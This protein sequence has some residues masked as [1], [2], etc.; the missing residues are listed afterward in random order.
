MNNY[1]LFNMLMIS[2]LWITMLV[3]LI[4]VVAPMKRQLNDIDRRVSNM[5]EVITIGGIVPNENLD[6]K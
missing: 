1:K 2:I 3:W 5:Y 6:I 4:G